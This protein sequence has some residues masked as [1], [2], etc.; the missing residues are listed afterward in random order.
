MVVSIGVAFAS[1]GLLRLGRG[2][3]R[4]GRRRR[5]ADGLLRAGVAIHP[6][7]ELLVRRAAELTGDRNRRMLSR[8]LVGIVR[9]CERPPLVS[10][11]PLD[12]RNVRPHVALVAALADRVGDLE[13]PVSARGMVLV[14]DLLTDGYASPLYIGGADGDVVAALERCLEALDGAAAAGAVYASSC[15]RIHDLLGA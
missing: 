12:R 14:E 3:L 6:A 15:D 11:V 4:L 1:Y 10:A 2:W 8:S 9:E 13:R 7:S 5:V